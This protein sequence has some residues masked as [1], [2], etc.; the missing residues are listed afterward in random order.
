[1]SSP[2]APVSG[3]AKN[4]I[5]IHFIIDV[6]DSDWTYFFEARTLN[7]K[8]GIFNSLIVNCLDEHAPVK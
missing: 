2:V 3:P 5:E 6:L 4:F 8:T 7:D 1:M